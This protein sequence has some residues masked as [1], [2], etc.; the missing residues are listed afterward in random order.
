MTSAVERARVPLSGWLVRSRIP[1]IAILISIAA[2]LFAQAAVADEVDDMLALKAKNQNRLKRYSA[3]YTVTTHQPKGVPNPKSLR[4]RYRLDVQRIPPGQVKNLKFPWRS[5]MEV[6]EPGRSRMRVEGDEVSY[7]GPDGKW[8]PIVLSA[9]QRQQVTDM[10]S[11]VVG[12]D[13]AEQRRIQDIKLVRKKNPI[14]G[15]RIRTLS[16]APSAK[17]KVKLYGRME[18]DISDDGLPLETRIYDASGKQTVVVKVKKHH[19][20]KGVSVV[21]EMESIAE[22][23][24]GV[25]VSQTTCSSLDVEFT[26]P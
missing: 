4:I 12:A 2:C 6:L 18:E 5:E 8:V 1:R 24:A 9:E 20:I 21:D 3:E 19:K 7:M 13:P 22:T 15:P 23:P 10:L 14:F 11:G 26:E 17:A 16:Y 25:I